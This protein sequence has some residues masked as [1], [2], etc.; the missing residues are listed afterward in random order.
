M[1]YWKIVYRTGEEDFETKEVIIDNEQYKLI[2][3]ALLRGEDFIVLKDKP[4]IKRSS[5]ASISEAD[6]IV[7]EIQRTGLKVDGLLEPAKHPLLGNRGGG[8]RKMEDILAEDHFA[9]YEKMGWEHKDD[10]ICK[11]NNKYQKVEQ[12]K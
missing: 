8:F 12:S 2:Q 10:C 11:T 3:N 1:K 7:S 5:I 6:D 9:Q 4:T